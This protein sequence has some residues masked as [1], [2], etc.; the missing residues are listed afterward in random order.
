MELGGGH[1][2]AVRLREVAC[3]AATQPPPNHYAVL[4]LPSGATP[5]EVR[6]AYRKLALQFHPDKNGKNSALP[7]AA[8]EQIFKLVTEAHGVLSDPDRRRA[9]DILALRFKYRQAC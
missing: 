6:S 3:A 2:V 7:A 4:G 5:A 9:H 8:A 1:E